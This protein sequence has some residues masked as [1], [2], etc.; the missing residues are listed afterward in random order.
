LTTRFAIVGFG[1]IG[2]RH[3][4][5]ILEQTGAVLVGICDTDE[6]K[7]TEAPADVPF[8]S[9][10]E[11][12][13]AAGGAD[14][15][16]ICTPNNLHAPQSIQALQAGCH[17]VVEKPMALSVSECDAMIAAAK[18]ADR[19]LFAVKQN[20]YNPPVAAV[21]ELLQAHRLGKI[22]MVQVNGFWNR[23]DAYYAQ[24]EWRRSKA[25]NGGCLFTQFSHFIDILFYLNGPV[26]SIQGRIKNF[27]HQHTTEFEDSGVFVMQGANGSLVNFNF[28]TCTY[29]RNMEGSVTLF[30]ERGTVKIGG[31]YLNAIDYSELEG[32]PL[33][34]LD[35]GK[36]ANQYGAYEGSMSNHDRVI[37]NVVA[38]LQQGHH[39]T[40]TAEEGREVVKMIE[41]M[42]KAAVT[43]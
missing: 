3:A 2:R 30:G 15:I 38:V 42:Y 19:H 23:N 26:T 8:Y 33:L 7:R 9:T 27:M 22:L 36:G 18:E 28:T 35:T 43:A 14:V 31:Q 6:Q 1:N 25:Q 17:V 20:R 34:V 39:M 16:C 40:T 24:S 4:H 21:K 32:E 12:M 11:D 13:L 10:L 41:E 5:H 37:Q 29:R